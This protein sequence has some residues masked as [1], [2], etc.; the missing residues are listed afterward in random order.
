MGGGVYRQVCSSRLVPV[1]VGREGEGCCCPS[2]RHPPAPPDRWRSDR[3]KGR[4]LAA[5]SH[6][7]RLS[8]SRLTE[9]FANRVIFPSSWVTVMGKNAFNHHFIF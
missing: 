4:G 8:A 7:G 1:P 9:I 6:G 2:R 5:P 3:S